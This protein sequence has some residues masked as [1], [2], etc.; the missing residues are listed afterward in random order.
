MM[1]ELLQDL[2]I[3]CE[4]DRARAEIA[5]GTV[6]SFMGTQLPSPLMGRVKS[7]LSTKE[8]TSTHHHPLMKDIGNA[9]Q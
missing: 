7:A 6:L 2:Q 8:K 5:L 4:I 1:D 3:N 9:V